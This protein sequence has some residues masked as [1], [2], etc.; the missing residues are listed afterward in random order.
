MCPTKHEVAA[1]I[2]DQRIK[3]TLPIER[4]VT[5]A[6]VDPVRPIATMNYIVADISQY[7]VGTISADHEIVTS[8]GVNHVVAIVSIDRVIA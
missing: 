8:S 2:A 3:P 5:E 7:T 1:I 4:V 6:T